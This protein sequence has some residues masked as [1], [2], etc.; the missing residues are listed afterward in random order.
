M[1]WNFKPLN[2]PLCLCMRSYVHVKISMDTRILNARA[3]TCTETTECKCLHRQCTSNGSSLRLARIENIRSPVPA[4][5]RR[6]GSKKWPTASFYAFVSWSEANSSWDME[7]WFLA[8]CDF[9]RV[10]PDLVYAGCRP[11]KLIHQFISVPAAAEGRYE[12]GRLN[13]FECQALP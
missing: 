12:A 7:T 6:F 10:W 3:G 1:G 9:H 4:P 5:T 11:L 8:T 2:V 13:S